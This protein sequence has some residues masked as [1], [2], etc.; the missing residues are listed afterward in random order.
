M[1]GSEQKSAK[2]GN[3]GESGDVLIRKATIEDLSDIQD[4]QRLLADTEQP[5]DALIDVAGT[6]TAEKSGYVGYVNMEKKLQSAD[7][8]VV[9]AVAESRAV[10]VCYGECKKDD[11]WNVLESFGYV[12][13]VFVEAKYRGGGER[14][15]WPKMLEALEKDF[16]KALGI[17]QL[18][19]DCYVDNPAAV[20]AYTKQNFRPVQY[21]MHK[22]VE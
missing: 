7:N 17:K 4:L 11:D 16:F 5:Y 10:G 3:L 20:K 15:V 12:G 6:K 2:E 21:I 18:R 8:Y 13:C 14:G 19:L 22:D 9:V 1:S